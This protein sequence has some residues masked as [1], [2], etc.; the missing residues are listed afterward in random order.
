M[1]AAQYRER[2]K[3]GI[4][5]ELKHR[6]ASRFSRSSCRKADVVT[7]NFSVGSDGAARSRLRGP[8][9][10]EARHRLR[11]DH[12][13]RPGRPVR[14]AAR[15]RHARAGDQRLHEHQRFSRGPADPIRPVDLRLLRRHALRVQ[16]R[17]RPALSR[18]HR[19]GP[20]HRH[21][22]ARQPDSSRLDNLGE[23]YTVG[24]RAPHARGQRLVRRLAARASIR[25]PTGTWRSPQARAT[26]SGAGSAR[27]SAA[28]SSRATPGSRPFR[29]GATGA[30]KSPRSS[31]AGRARAP[32][33]KSSR[34]CPTAASPPPRSTTSPRWSPIPQV[35]AR[36]MFVE[37]DHPTY[38]RSR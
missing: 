19:Q 35:Q 37:H 27:S 12:R 25:R 17:V 18:P 2:N 34:R 3:L 31:R 32:R 5:L 8:E 20:A 28:A 36:D 21:R 7:E 13:V 29:P 16:H 33:P 26:R 11:L 4:T 30:I 38:G 15:L 14:H 24:R 10:R 22:A 23:R 9:A 6:A 1:H